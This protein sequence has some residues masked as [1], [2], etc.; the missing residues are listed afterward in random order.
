MQIHCSANFYVPES[1]SVNSKCQQHVAHIE[2]IWI[3]DNLFWITGSAGSLF[4]WGRKPF[5]LESWILSPALVGFGCYVVLL[6]EWWFFNSC[7]LARRLVRYLVPAMPGNGVGS[8]LQHMALWCFC[9]TLFSSL[10]QFIEV[11][12]RVRGCPGCFW[13][14]YSTYLILFPL[15]LGHM[16]ACWPDMKQMVTKDN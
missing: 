6:V 15:Q 13:P 5:L 7:C 11:E 8:S 2:M 12:W 10:K 9:K 4:S 1:T 16:V 3:L 14:H